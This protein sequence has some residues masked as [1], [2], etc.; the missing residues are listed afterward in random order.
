[1]FLFTTSLPFPET[2][3]ECERVIVERNPLKLLAAAQRVLWPLR[4]ALAVTTWDTEPGDWMAKVAAFFIPWF[5]VLVKNEN[6]DF[7][8]ATPPLVLRH[9]LTRLPAQF[10]R[11]RDWPRRTALPWLFSRAAALRP[12]ITERVFSGMRGSSALQI[13]SLSSAGRGV[14]RFPTHLKGWDWRRVLAIAESTDCRWILFIHEGA[15]TP[16]DD[17]I[18]LFDDPRTFVVSRQMDFRDWEPTLVSRTPFRQLQTNEASQ[19]LAPIGRVMLVDR[20]K[21]LALG[22]PKT[23][24]GCAAWF[25]LFWKAAAAGWRSYAVGGREELNKTS[26]WPA[27]E[28]EFVAGLL[29]DPKIANLMPL[30]P[31]LARGNVA[32][33]NRSRS[34]TTGKPR[35]LVVSPYLPYPLSHGGAVRIY[36]LCRALS[37]RM[38]FLLVC[39]RE[40]SEAV[41]YGKLHEVF[42]RVYVI[43]RDQRAIEGSPLP[44]RVAEYDTS[45]LHALVSEIC[46]RELPDFLQVEY[47]QLASVREAAPRIPAIWVEHDVTFLLQRAIARHSRS[48]ADSIEAEKWYGYE[49]KWFH[50]YDAVWTMCAEDRK[51]A[52]DAGSSPSRTL[53]V[54]N[55]VDTDR[56]RPREGSAQSPELLFAGAFRHHPNVL[57]FETLVREIMPRV[58]IEFPSARLRVVAGCEP[59]R[60]WRGRL[61]DRVELQEFV[62]DL[63]PLYARAWVVT[64]PLA[65]SAGTNIKVLEAMACGKAIVSTPAG[66]RGLGLVNAADCLI[67]ETSEAFSDGIVQL[68][69]DESLRNDLGRQA[70]HCAERR[71]SWAAIA[72]EAYRSYAGLGLPSVH[73]ETAA[74]FIGS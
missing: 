27:E 5:R 37:D 29:A 65:V 71:F 36:N 43:D 66:C 67:R 64:A 22:I 3:I 21:L 10:I 13:V 42:Q 46:K 39:F 59:Q 49:R 1:V 69:K 57:A 11:L 25:T 70:R 40:Q 18:P 38:D 35:V 48:E 15:E 56:F 7:F 54:G 51:A 47:T 8:P 12:G 34:V 45:T 58:W 4:V 28:R 6:D 17:L 52:L 33:C 14:F 30:E 53:V 72:A 23:T 63:R 24:N 32:F 55:G 2:E 74:T 19:T 68:L 62:A 61:D 20:E 9:A 50:K 16:L 73:R 26:G 44:Q 41:N 31:D 60:Y